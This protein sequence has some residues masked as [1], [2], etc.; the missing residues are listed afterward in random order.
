MQLTKSL[1]QDLVKH[2][3][4]QTPLLAGPE[5]TVRE[6]IQLLQEK[7]TGCLM[8]CDASGKAVGIFTE[9][10]ILNRI[11]AVEKPPGTVKVKDVMTTPMAC[12][13][14][15]T[16]LAEC[17]SVMT[18][19]RIRHLPIV[20]NGKLYGMISS[21]DILGHDSAEQQATIRHGVRAMTGRSLE[22]P[23]KFVVEDP[24]NR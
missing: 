15:D 13:R 7:K 20:E 5:T 18:S 10:D 4:Y 21:G 6:A 9:R 17:K 1:N 19:K 12:G 3:H 2:L 22:T 11:V 23:H 24:R 16:K 8:V 14:R